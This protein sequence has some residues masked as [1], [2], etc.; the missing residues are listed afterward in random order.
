MRKPKR[1]PNVRMDY[2]RVV[3][4]PT[5]AIIT[6]IRKKLGLVSQDRQHYEGRAIVEGKRTVF[7]FNGYGVDELDMLTKAR[8]HAVKTI[9]KRYRMNR[10]DYKK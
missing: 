6:E 2:I 9:Q 3:D 4:E 5:D 10:Y 7:I 1:N 8:E